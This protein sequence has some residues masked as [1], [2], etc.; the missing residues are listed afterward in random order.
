MVTVCRCG[1]GSGWF[2]VMIELLDQAGWMG[3]CLQTESGWWMGVDGSVLGLMGGVDAVFM[4]W[5][6]GRGGLYCAF[7]DLERSFMGVPKF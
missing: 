4:V 2:W 1:W 3:K 7:V 6:L 5:H